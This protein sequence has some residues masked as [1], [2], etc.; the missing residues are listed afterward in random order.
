MFTNA[1]EA[2]RFITGGNAI[3]T[4]TSPKT[5]KSFTYKVSAA[6]DAVLDTDTMRF[7]RVLA[8]PDNISWAD[9]IYIGFIG[10][11]GELVA[12]RK[13]RAQAPAFKALAW[14]LSRLNAGRL[15][16]E[17]RHE[18]ACGRC[19]RPLTVPASIDTGF[20]PHCAAQ[21]GIDWVTDDHEEEPAVEAPASPFIG[22]A[23]GALAARL[24]GP[25][26]IDA[27]V[28]CTTVAPTKPPP[29]WSKGDDIDDLLNF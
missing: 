3:F 14:T 4:V 19:G 26:L 7:V 1:I 27:N 16:V 11:E 21:L 23:P 8:G 28:A 18:G 6:K 2:R 5:A 17:I 20:G 12:G 29:D 25:A 13:G 22:P 10:R 24:S 9:S 15:D